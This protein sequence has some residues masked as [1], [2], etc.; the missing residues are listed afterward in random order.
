MTLSII[1]PNDPALDVLQSALAERPDLD[2]KLTIIP[3]PEYREALMATLT[4]VS[5][6]NQAVFVPGHI[7]LPEF[8]AAG[9]LA[10]IAPLMESVSAE[11]L[12]SYDPDDIVLSIADECE[13]EGKQYQLPF[14]SDGHILFYRADLIELDESDGIPIVS[15]RDLKELAQ[16]TSTGSAHSVHNPPH[17]YGLALKADAS[18]IFT[19]FLPYLWEAG[20]RIFDENGRPDIDNPV[21][22]EV[23]ELYCSLRELCP[24]QTAVY[25]NGEIADVLRNG[26]AALVANWGGQT[27]PIMLDEGWSG[28]YKTAVFPIPW[29]ATWGIAI[30]RNQSAA[31]QQNAI[32]ALMQLLGTEQDKQITRMAGSPVRQSSYAPAELQKYPWLA[33]QLEMLNRAKPLPARPELGSFLGL[34]YEATHQAFMGKLSPAEALA[35]VQVKA[36]EA[37]A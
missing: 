33:A 23:L 37:L 26:E 29:N 27:A 3:W 31:S 12:A 25:G 10:E 21:N 17:I 11:L 4:A 24:P 28:A 20:G 18:E 19:D 2:A 9:Y 6:P 36:L 16:A 1:G 32:A 7:W 34:L 35:N 30:P 5:A 8:A 15:T 22:I 14:F 13:Y